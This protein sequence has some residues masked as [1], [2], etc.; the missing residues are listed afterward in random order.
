MTEYP[1]ISNMISYD[2][3]RAVTVQKKGEREY[4]VQMFDL[5]TYEKTFDE[6]VGGESNDYIKIK[7]VEQNSAGNKFA[8]VY[9]NDGQFK[10]RDFNRE[11]R[12]EDE[13]KNNEVDVN[14]LIGIDT[15]TMPIQGFSDPYIVCCFVS[16][17]QVFVALYHNYSD[18]HYHFIYD[19]EM[20]IIIGETVSFKMES[21]KKNFP[22]KSFYNADLNEVYLFYRQG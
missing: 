2:S 7:D 22:Y 18:M 15:W 9:L 21:N 12:S 13:I 8:L 3:K 19:I 10:F 17:T 1:I 14:K 4:R 16:D 20:K 5:E 6:A 11:W